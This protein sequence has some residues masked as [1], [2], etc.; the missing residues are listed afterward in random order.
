MRKHLDQLK[1]PLPSQRRLF[2]GHLLRTQRL[3]LQPLPHIRIQI[4]GH[5]L[6]ITALVGLSVIT[7]PEFVTREQF[8]NAEGGIC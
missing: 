6:I 5:Q 3:I 2:S 7:L 1:D 8:P 4:G